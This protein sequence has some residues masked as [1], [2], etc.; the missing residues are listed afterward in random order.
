MFYLVSK[1]DGENRMPK[2]QGL[3]IKNKNFK[4]DY[5]VWHALINKVKEKVFS[6]KNVHKY[7][8]FTKNQIAYFIR[9]GVLE[10]EDTRKWRRFSLLDLFILSVAKHLRFR[11]VEVAALPLKD[12]KVMMESDYSEPFVYIINGY[13]AFF[14]TDFGN[15]TGFT[16]EHTDTN[17]DMSKM[18]KAI[19]KDHISVRLNI[20]IHRTSSVFIGVSLGTV[21]KELIDKIDL[22][23]FRAS[24]QE[25][26]KYQFV[27]NGIP[28]KLE[29]LEID[30]K[31]EVK[32][33]IEELKEL[34][35][36]Q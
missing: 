26:G 29:S 16:A 2:F 31:K 10:S 36:D 23:D 3:Q 15:V 18:N 30:E 1:N 13:D 4:R 9:K 7:T 8:G 6:F 14:Y 5:P 24:I 25:D 34:Y 12:G 28:L 11:G 17:D 33:T 35:K 32:N 21:L 19:T 20:D 22:P 27:I